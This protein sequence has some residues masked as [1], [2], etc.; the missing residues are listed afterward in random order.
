MI[1]GLCGALSGEPD[2]TTGLYINNYDLYY[3]Y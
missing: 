1:L 2:T 3:L